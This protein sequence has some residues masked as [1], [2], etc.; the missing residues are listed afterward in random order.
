VIPAATVWPVV[1]KRLAAL[2]PAPSA[3][4]II[5]C[6]PVSIVSIISD[7]NARPTSANSTAAAPDVLRAFIRPAPSGRQSGLETLSRGGPRES[8]RNA[9]VTSP[10]MVVLAIGASTA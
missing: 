7:M 3:E 10:V 6:Q 8:T 9:A 2:A 1:P 4:S 5:S